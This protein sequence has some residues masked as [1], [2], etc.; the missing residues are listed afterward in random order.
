M[1]L[2]FG[3]VYIWILN[4]K[5]KI[6]SL[7]H[8]TFWSHLVWHI[9]IKSIKEE[10]EIV[11]FAY[12]IEYQDIYREFEP[13]CWHHKSGLVSQVS[14]ENNYMIIEFLYFFSS[15]FFTSLLFFLLSLTSF[16]TLL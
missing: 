9:Q 10:C 15:I 4:F 13:L 5:I 6:L 11:S 12:H 1:L 16:P 7:G 3:L 8:D 14:L 2:S